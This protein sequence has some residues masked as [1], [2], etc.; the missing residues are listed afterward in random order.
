MK[1]ASERT[2]S[3]SKR[4][5]TQWVESLRSKKLFVG[6]DRDGTLVPLH[7][8]PAKALV[9]PALRELI[10]KCAGLP[11]TVLCVLSARSIDQLRIDFGSSDKMILAGNYG[12][13]ISFPQGEGYVHPLARSSK[14]LLAEAGKELQQELGKTLPVVLEDHGLSICL[15]WHLVPEA[16]RNYVHQTVELLK[17]KYTEIYFKTLPTSYELLPTNDWNKGRALEQISIT[18]NNSNRLSDSES[19]YLYAGDSHADEPAFSFVNMRK[20]LS[21]RVGGRGETEAALELKSESEMIEF[22]SEIIDLRSK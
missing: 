19:I 10:C 13:E 6:L 12:M 22:I 3:K 4:I 15:H 20:G 1:S 14:G 11:E 9:S 16:S 5:P 8:D 17:G 7:E 18:L 2:S 21:I